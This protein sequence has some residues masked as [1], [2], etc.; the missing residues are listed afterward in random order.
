M[1]Q[2]GTAKPNPRMGSGVARQRSLLGLFVRVSGLW[3]LLPVCRFKDGK[4]VIKAGNCHKQHIQMGRGRTNVWTRGNCVNIYKKEGPLSPYLMPTVLANPSLGF[5]Y[6]LSNYGW[7]KLRGCPLIHQDDTIWIMPGRCQGG[8]RWGVE[9]ERFFQSFSD[10][11]FSQFNSTL[12]VRSILVAQVK[13][14]RIFWDR[15]PHAH[16]YTPWTVRPKQSEQI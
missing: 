15:I 3:E 16:S 12:K 7:G 1:R 8:S 13:G 5:S 2:P 4:G 11:N 6:S 10:P 9:G 14:K